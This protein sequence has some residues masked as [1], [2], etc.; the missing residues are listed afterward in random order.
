[1]G[2][3]FGLDFIVSAIKFFIICL[4][5][6]RKG[7]GGIVSVSLDGH[8]LYVQQLNISIIFLGGSVVL[9]RLENAVATELFLYGE[10]SFGTCVHGLD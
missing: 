7:S 2:R 8:L 4:D 9:N 5:T 10:E 3:L 6:C 1:M